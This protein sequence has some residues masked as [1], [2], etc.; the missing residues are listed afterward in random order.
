[1]FLKEKLISD[2]GL[3]SPYGGQQGVANEQHSWGFFRDTQGF[4][5]L[6]ADSRTGLAS[7][8]FPPP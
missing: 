5:Q 2:H 4:G 1:M 6:D 8:R 7:S 3:F